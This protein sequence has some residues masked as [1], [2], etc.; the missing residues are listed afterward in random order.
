MMS[1]CT[2]RG[3]IFKNVFIR[4]GILGSTALYGKKTVSTLG[5][6]TNAFDSQGTKFILPKITGLFGVP[7]L[8]DSS[9]FTILCEKA[10][11]ESQVLVED[12]LCLANEIKAGKKSVVDLITKFDHLSNTVCN[13]ADL[14][15][16]VRLTHPNSEYQKSAGEVSLAINGFVEKLNTNVELYHALTRSLGS[17]SSSELDEES[18]HVADS[19]VFDFEQSGIHL[20]DSKRAKF[21]KLQD[22]VLRLG[23]QFVAGTSA[24]TFFPKKFWPNDVRHGFQ[25]D[26]EYIQIDGL[27]YDSPDPKLREIVYKAYM[28]SNPAQLTILDDLLEARH[29]LAKLV[30]FPS[31][32]SRSLRGT[33]AD[34]PETVQEFLTILAERIHPLISKDNELLMNIKQDRNNNNVAIMPWDIQY[35]TGLAKAQSLQNFPVTLSEY[36]SLGTCMEGLNVIFENLYGITLEPTEPDPGEVWHPSVVKLTVK[37]ENEGILGYIYCDLYYRE[38]KVQ[39]DCHFTIRGGCQLPDG[40]Y[41]LPVV[42]IVCNFPVPQQPKATLLT[43]GM[44]ENLYH[45]MGHAMHSML[46]R[47]KYQHVTGTRMTTDLVEV[48]SILMEYYVWDPTILGK[49]GRHY[50]SGKKLPDEAVKKFCQLRNSFSSLEMQ[51]Q[52]FYSMVDQTYHGK[53]PL[54]KTTTE[55][56]KDLQTK[57]MSTPYIEGTSWQQRF[58]H[59]H[60]G[61]AGRYYSYLWCRA[62]ASRIWRK[63]FV[64]DPLSREAG[65]RFRNTFLK[66]GGGREPRKLVEDML[67]QEISVNDLVRALENELHAIE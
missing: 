64:A 24:P 46:G 42:A 5:Q 67:G 40:S 53:H 60:G 63:W 57:Y 51:T 23:S 50:R 22:R 15:E 21:V 44:I 12:A 14:A 17:A 9:G 61:Y 43:H 29:D 11:N 20:D 13:V 16:F 1:L 28:L 39:Q 58:S 59:L 48:P 2:L 7:E 62:V 38:N 8:Y 47:T 52:V 45:E 56:L 10:L 19:L 6:L 4:G 32:L 36:F 49:V 54:G 26:D 27:C 18:R 25:S 34:T 3:N 31:F 33:M 35:Y 41:Q 37:H 66:Y 65:E 55:I 30:G